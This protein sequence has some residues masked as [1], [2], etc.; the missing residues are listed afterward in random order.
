MQSSYAQRQTLLCKCRFPISRILI[1]AIQDNDENFAP[2]LFL[3][4]FL[5]TKIWGIDCLTSNVGCGVAWNSLLMGTLVGAGTAALGLAFA[6]IATRT[7]FRA[8]KLLRVLTVLPIIT[9]PFVIGLA[10]ILLFGRSGA[11]STFLEWAWGIEASRW[12]YGLGDASG[13]NVFQG[14]A[15]FPH[16]HRPVGA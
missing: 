14:A 3:E 11:I 4:K 9:P 5:S 6:L 2:A 16:G 10:V 8:K 1:S 12:I 15:G 13:A 7:G